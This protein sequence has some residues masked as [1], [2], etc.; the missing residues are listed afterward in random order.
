MKK[1]CALA[2]TAFTA[3]SACTVIDTV[4]FL[5]VRAYG[6]ATVKNHVTQ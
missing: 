1:T 2:I 5:R 6:T 4:Q 3:L